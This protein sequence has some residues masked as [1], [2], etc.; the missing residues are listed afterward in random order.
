MASIKKAEA[1]ARPSES[2]REGTPKIEFRTIA[3]LEMLK[4]GGFWRIFTLGL[5]LREA[6][7][8]FF[9]KTSSLF[10]I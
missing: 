10:S 3:L 9:E 1:K 8:Q 4:I 2:F 6:N 7:R 5:F